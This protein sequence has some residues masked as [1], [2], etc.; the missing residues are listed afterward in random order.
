MQKAMQVGHTRRAYLRAALSWAMAG[1]LPAMAGEITPWPASGPL[2]PLDVVDLEGRRWSNANVRGRAVLLNFW[3]SWCE[4]C[5]A[6]MP[7][8][9]QLVEL[10]GDKQL[11]V[12]AINFKESRPTAASFARRTGMNLP[13]VLDPDGKF[14]AQCGVKI[15]P[16]TIGL[17]ADGV[18]RWRARGDMD[19]SSAESGKRVEALFQ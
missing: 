2:P 12:L 6:E 9:Q 18:P 14:T 1:T 15:F 10:Y 5:R 11:V 3:A 7:V 4:P 8:L 19:W 17:G 16:T 13:I